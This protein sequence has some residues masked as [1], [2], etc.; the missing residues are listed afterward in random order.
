[1]DMKGLKF[2]E[3]HEWI[4][5]EGNKAYIGI[6][7]YAQKEL[8]DIVYIELPPTGEKYSSGD[9]L[10]EV[11]SVKAVSNVFAPLTGE[12]LEVNEELTHSPELINKEPFGKGWIAVIEIENPDELKGLMSAEEYEEFCNSL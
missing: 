9:E 1:M 8:G 4:R 10:A 12:V 6:T 7:E 11:E 3:E 2:T 5:V